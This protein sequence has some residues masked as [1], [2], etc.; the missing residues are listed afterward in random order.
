VRSQGQRELSYT[1][2]EEIQVGYQIADVIDD[3]DLGRRY[4]PAI[5]SILHFQFL[6]R[7]PCDIVIDNLTG[8][9][10]T[11]GRVDREAICKTDVEC[12]VRLDVAVQPMAYFS[13]IKVSI[14]ILDINDNDPEFHPS[15]VSHDMIESSALQTGFVVQG[16]RDNDIGVNGVKTYELRQ[17][18]DSEHFDLKVIHRM[19]G[20]IDA[21]V[22]LSFLSTRFCIILR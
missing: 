8:I 21:K 9:I 15:Q 12:H 16:A 17:T 2:D 13:I 14:E 22:T 1:I 18:I 3:A 4:T 6:S 20:S 10:R 5:L 11:G 7:P 19:D